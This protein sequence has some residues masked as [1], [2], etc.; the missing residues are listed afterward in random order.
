MIKSVL[1][2]PG[3][4]LKNDNRLKIGKDVIKMIHVLFV[5]LG[6]ICR[7]PMCEAVFRDMLD[8][9]GLTDKVRVDSAG[10]SDWH[11]DKPPHEGTRKVLDRANISYAGMV[12]RQ[13]H[14]DDWT[15]FD[16][17]IV[18]DHDNREAIKSGYDANKDVVLA[19]LTDFMKDPEAVNVPDPYY[20]G[21]FNDTY[22]L[23]T[24]GCQALLTHI[25]EKHNI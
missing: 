23:V 17:V 19:M 6:N 2:L 20:T 21:N 15:H 12:G 14:T 22:E 5:C 10:T 25:R 18:M 16:Y 8:Q 11:L 9:A 4:P 24:S 3:N 13:F 7:S 1:S